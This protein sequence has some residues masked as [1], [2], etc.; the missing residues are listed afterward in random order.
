MPI[1]NCK[2]SKNVEI[3]HENLVNLYGCT[4]EEYTKIGPFVEIQSNV[5][6]GKYNKIWQLSDLQRISKT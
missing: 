2:I 5:I 3:L 6:I 1:K 4:I